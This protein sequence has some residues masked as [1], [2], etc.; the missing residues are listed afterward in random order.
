MKITKS[1]GQTDTE[2][3]LAQLCEKTFLKIW[4]YLNPYKSDGKEL[5]DLI[6]IFE[7]HIF[8]FFDRESKKFENKDKEIK[9][10]WQRWKKK[11]ID[12]QASTAIGA[13][14]YITSVKGDIYL[15]DKCQ[16]KI[17]IEIPNHGVIVHK[18]IVAHGAEAACKSYSTNNIN[19]SLGMIYSDANNDLDQMV[20][21]FVVNQPIQDKIHIFDSYNLPI[22]LNEL[23]TVSDFTDY[24]I[25]KER[26]FQN[27]KFMTYSGEED[28]LAQYLINFDDNTNK[29]YIIENNEIDGLIIPEGTWQTYIQSESCKA[30]IEANE[31]SYLWDNLI[32]H[33][34][35]HA[36]NGR[37]TGNANIFSNENP[38]H[39]MAKEPRTIRRAISNRL[40]HA[41]NNFPDNIT[42]NAPMRQITFVGSNEQ[43]KAYLILQL[44]TA[45][46]ISN[47]DEYTN[48]RK[49]ML[50]I[51]CGAAKNKFNALELII[52]IAMDAPKHRKEGSEDFIFFECSEWNE[53]L[54]NE[55]L[56]LNIHYNFFADKTKVNH[57]TIFEY[58]V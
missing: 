11:V 9:L 32:Q 29:H 25:E 55:Y 26:V 1:M 49:K 43:N 5:C 8:V 38:I 3:Y 58:P 54:K 2:K 56:A 7:N 19:G 39:E 33:V 23:D 36:L 4:S 47:Y 14:R 10:T 16:N 18:I 40:Y 44:A 22:I 53:S 24:I 17:P 15:D 37:L 50:E 35:E 51:A 57:E 27:M 42:D 34:G 48:M 41:F 45:D 20:T 21:P 28:L 52:G 12:K 13:E 46:K 6:V 30:K 31:I